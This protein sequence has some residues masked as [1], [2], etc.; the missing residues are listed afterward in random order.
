MVVTAQLIRRQ[1]H[2]LVHRNWQ[3]ME[4]V[5]SE[6]HGKVLADIVAPEIRSMQDELDNRAILTELTAALAKGKP[7]GETGSLEMGG[8]ETD[9]LA[10]AIALG[11]WSQLWSH[12]ILV[13]ILNGILNGC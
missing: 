4:Q 5:L 1:R 9:S 2:A 10:D 12:C 3:R 7:S 11:K 8:V 6:A 13:D